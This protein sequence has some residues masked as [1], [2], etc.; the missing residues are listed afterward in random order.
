MIDH[1][2][3]RYSRPFGRLVMHVALLAGAVPAL[4]WLASFSWNLFA[5]EMFGLRELG[6]REA[7]GMVLLGGIASAVLGLRRRHSRHFT[8]L[9]DD[10]T[11]AR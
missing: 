5:P 7:L 4:A 9:E 3:K 8:E 1:R 2:S 6:M 11:Q 10:V